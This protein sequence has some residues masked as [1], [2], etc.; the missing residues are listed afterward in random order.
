MLINKFKKD[1]VIT[2]KL[3]NGEELI[4]LFKEEFGDEI[5][6]SSPCVLTMGSNGNLGMIPWCLLSER[7]EHSIKKSQTFIIAKTRKEACDQY[8]ESAVNMEVKI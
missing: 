1:E 4:A 5:T 2:I 8:L 3:I 6:I 7:K